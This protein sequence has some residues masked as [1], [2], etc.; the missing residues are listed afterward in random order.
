[1]EVGELEV[2]QKV[3]EHIEEGVHVVDSR[4]RTVLYNRAAAQID[5]LE[6]EEVMGKHV[7]EVF[8]SLSEST[9]TLL[10]VIATGKAIHQR[11]QSFMNYKGKQ[12]TT[13]NTTVPLW[14]AGRVVGAVEISKNITEVR[15]MSEKI[16]D[17]QA[18]LYSYGGPRDRLFEFR[19]IVTQDP[20]M[21]EL[22]EVARKA[23]RT[24]SSVLVWGETGTGKELFVQAIHTGSARRNGPFVAQ[25]CA[26]VPETLL[27]GILFG[28]V[29]GAFTGASDRPGLFE[30]AEKG[31]LYLDEVNSMP[32][33]TQAKLLRAVQEKKVRRL[34]YSHERP[35]D[36]RIVA[37]TNMDPRQAVEQRLLRED[38]YY[39]LNVISI[40]IPPLRQRKQDVP[41]LVDHFIRKWNARLGCSFEGVSPDVLEL[42]MEYDWPGN[43]RQL[44]NVIE[45]AMG[46]GEGP[47]IK[48]D[49]LP[50]TLVH[51]IFSSRG[52]LRRVFA[53]G[54]PLT[55]KGPDQ[56]W[57]ATV[58]EESGH[59][60]RD[61]I[62]R[63]EEQIVR[64]AFEECNFNV[65]KTARV[66]GVPR[67]TLQ[68][69]LKK[70]GLSRPKAP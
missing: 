15:K 23:A 11:Q 36:V 67:Q 43:V 69:R 32:L 1:M 55:A 57:A 66:L 61:R 31:T 64:K 7:L 47:V 2:L 22:K 46:I 48:L 59:G 68:Y 39:R 12:I 37:S 8:P 5:G 27:E 3:L 30:L 38:L 29:R 24:S 9:S 28:T 51:A 63:L 44:E 20:V 54:R 21:L 70:L 56:N 53:P 50:H 10:Q 13:V 14:K 65:S 33:A 58:A 62:H 6:V 17:L 41:L 52:E 45:A 26:A 18:E 60:L 25:N 19:D 16:M 42:F 49:H 35:V 40:A 4:G 34:G